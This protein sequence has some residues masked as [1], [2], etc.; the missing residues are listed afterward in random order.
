MNVT[1]KMKTYHSSMLK[2]EAVLDKYIRLAYLILMVFTFTVL[3]CKDNGVEPQNR[4]LQLNDTSEVSYHDTISNVNDGIWL[5][6]DSVVT[7]T[8]CPLHADCIGD[9]DEIVVRMTFCK[10]IG[11]ASFLLSSRQISPSGYPKEAAIAGY[12]IK[13][14][15]VLPYPDITVSLP[16]NYLPEHYKIMILVSK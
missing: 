3:H 12:S 1:P 11:K 6:F 4:P 2:K 5:S 8:R 10:A 13:L 15:N 7:D 9:S 16:K 14:L